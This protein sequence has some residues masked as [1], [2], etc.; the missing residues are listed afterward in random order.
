MRPNSRLKLGG[1]ERL[2]DII[3]GTDVQEP[4]LLIVGM[5]GRENDDR[6]R[7][8]TAHFAADV[9]AGHVGQPEIE[10]DEVGPRGSGEINALSA[11]RSLDDA[12]AVDVHGVAD[13]TTD[14]WF[15][16]DDED[17][18]RFP[19]ALRHQFLSHSAPVRS[20]S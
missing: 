9:C 6:R 7:A 12:P 2:R 10:H 18:G 5:P 16:I 19:M 11:R 1:A 3:V 17:G 14:L 15:V 13:D 8:P 20:W 4:D